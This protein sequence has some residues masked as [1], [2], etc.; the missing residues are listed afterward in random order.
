MEPNQ[1][2]PFTIRVNWHKEQ[3]ADW[4]NDTCAM[5]LNVFGSPGHK[6]IYHPFENYMEF[7]FKSKKDAT[8]CKILLSDRL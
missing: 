3:G 6:F 4:W 1:N 5:V 2:Y 7:L 8:I